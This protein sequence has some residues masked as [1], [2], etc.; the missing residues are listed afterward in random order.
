M[1][2]KIRSQIEAEITGLMH[3]LHVDLPERIK[4]AREHGDLRE[5]A[6]FKAAK[7]RQGFVEARLNHLT[8]RMT[9]LSKIDV[10]DMAYDKAGFG[11]TVTIHD[12]DL[13]ED[14][15][16]TITAGDFIDLDAGQVSLASPIGQGLLGA[17][18]GEEVTIK[19]PAGARQYKIVELSTLPQQMEARGS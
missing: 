7:E 11:S 17:E 10:K 8:T 6:E 5:N 16:F 4:I 1:L 14:F 9:E 18:E 13:D 15:T 19:L 12:I 2:E 3:E